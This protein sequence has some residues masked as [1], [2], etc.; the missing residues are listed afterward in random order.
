V[1]IATGW[2]TAGF[3]LSQRRDK[4]AK[5]YLVYDYEILQMADT[6]IRRRITATYI[7]ALP[8]VA[9]SSVV[10]EILSDHGVTPLAT[11]P[12]GID[13]GVYHWMR[14]PEARPLRVG[15]PAR[16]APDKGLQDALDAIDQVRREQPEDSM[17]V[18][19]FGPVRP[20][21][22]PEWV[23]F[24]ERPTDT[25]IAAFLNDCSIFVFPSHYE[26]WG[27]PAIE[28][29]AC[30]AALVTYDNGGSRDYAVDEVTALVAQPRSPDAL[31]ARITRLLTDVDLRCKL[32]AAARSHVMR[33][34]WD[35]AVLALE[36][37]LGT[38]AAEHR[39]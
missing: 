39:W 23:E 10:H 26:A 1:L 8:A 6:N 11:I 5:L 28:A 3:V 9:T 17:V 16:Q 12:C 4:G 13:F 31:A 20:K 32:A 14:P 22:I 19:A 29:M 37:L 35:A 2:Q 36:E 30:G 21:R 15:F 18:A 24:V 25:E 33:Y 7:D 34:D 27:L 38:V